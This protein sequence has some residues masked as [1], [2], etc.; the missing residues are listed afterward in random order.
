MDERMEAAFVTNTPRAGESPEQT[1]MRN[2]RNGTSTTDPGISSID[3]TR[4][5]ATDFVDAITNNTLVDLTRRRDELDNC[6]ER[7]RTS[8]RALTHYIGEFA[9]FNYEALE[10]SRDIGNAIR[11]ATVPFAKD[12]PATITQTPAHTNGKDETDAQI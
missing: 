12:P 8:Q 5:R 3:A 11:A 10:L 2:A 4:K 7:I 9:R 6:M 1:A